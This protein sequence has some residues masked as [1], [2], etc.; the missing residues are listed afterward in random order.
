VPRIWFLLALIVAFLGT[1][2]RLAEAAS[3]LARSM[4]ESE[5]VGA[6]EVI[7]GGVGDDSGES[8]RSD[9]VHFALAWT[10][11]DGLT[12]YCS[13]ASSPR[14]VLPLLD[15]A[16]STWTTLGSTRRHVLLERFLC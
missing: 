6:I 12:G 5:A 15:D 1:P 3:D 16:P 7:D 10:F 4:V 2:F 9:L 14:R 13:L 11:V 8:I